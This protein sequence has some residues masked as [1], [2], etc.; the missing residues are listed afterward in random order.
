MKIKQTHIIARW[1]QN[2]PDSY[3][4]LVEV[5]ECVEVTPRGIERVYVLKDRSNDLQVIDKERF[6][7]MSSTNLI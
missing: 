1:V 7:R 3:K 6:E 2:G 4:E 5:H